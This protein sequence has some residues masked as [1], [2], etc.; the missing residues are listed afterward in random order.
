MFPFNIARKKY[1]EL[2]NE[3][4]VERSPIEKR[5]NAVC[6]VAGGLFLCFWGGLILVLIWPSLIAIPNM[7]GTEL[8]YVVATFVV[9]SIIFL[10]GAVLILQSKTPPLMKRFFYGL[11]SLPTALFG[12]AMG[13]FIIQDF[14]FAQLLLAVPAACIVLGIYWARLAFSKTTVK[15][16]IAEYREVPRV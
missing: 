5:F 3:I 10:A 14:G 6:C 12:L 15:D 1:N 7:K 4:T 8:L 9:C 16:V 13:Y 2:K 11:L